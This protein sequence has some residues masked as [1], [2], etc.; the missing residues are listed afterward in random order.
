MS[1]ICHCQYVYTNTTT[2]SQNPHHFTYFGVHVLKWLFFFLLSLRQQT[3]WSSC[4]R[5]VNLNLLVS[6][7]TRPSAP[8]SQ[9]TC[10]SSSGAVKGAGKSLGFS[11][12][13]TWAFILPA[14]PC[15]MLWRFVIQQQTPTH[16]HGL[17]N[18]VPSK[19]IGMER[20]VLQ[21]VLYT[22]DIWIWDKK[23]NISIVDQ[24][25]SFRF[26]IFVSRCTVFNN[27]EHDIFSGRLSHFRW[28]KV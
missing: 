28:S 18:T 10:C 9:T 11:H 15:I 23:M 24:N 19:S 17:W 2:M 12:L 27:L 25:F 13:E 14:L 7:R 8:C 16:T 5:A 4:V 20:P 21:F 3:Q 1:I 22:E 26:P 6:Q